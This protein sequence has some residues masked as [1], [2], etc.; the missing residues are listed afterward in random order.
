MSIDQPKRDN[1]YL[2]WCERREQMRYYC[3]CQDT[4]LKFDQGEDHEQGLK[5]DCLTDMKHR[6][7]KAV[8]MR[9]EEKE[10]G[11]PIYYIK[12]IKQGAPVPDQIDI[13]QPPVVANQP[14]QPPKP[15]RAQVSPGN[16]LQ[17]IINTMS[18]DERTGKQ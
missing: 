15:K 9:W 8:A 16:E 6:R 10:K 18:E 5:S 2:F 4:M 17:H 1:A 12:R 11:Q 13:K 7:C 14:L 3:A